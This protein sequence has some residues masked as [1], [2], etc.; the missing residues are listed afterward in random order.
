M[1][2]L[3]SSMAE[4]AAAEDALTDA[5]GATGTPVAGHPAATLPEEVTLCT[6]TSGCEA[7][8]RYSSQ[9]TYHPP[10]PSG[11]AQGLPAFEVGPPRETPL[12]GQVAWTIPGAIRPEKTIVAATAESAD[13]LES[14][15]SHSLEGDLSGRIELPDSDI[16]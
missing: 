15:I 12:A 7:L 13:G 9:V 2:S 10:E 4:T 16:A 5:V 8:A 11:I 6:Y 1:A 14:F 3:A